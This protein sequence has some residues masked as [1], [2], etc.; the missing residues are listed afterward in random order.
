MIV[1]GFRHCRKVLLF[2]IIFL[3]CTAGYS[4]VIQCGTINTPIEN[5]AELKKEGTLR[6]KSNC[7]IRISINIITQQDGFHLA[8]NEDR[9]NREVDIANT[10]FDS[11]GITLILTEIK[12]IAREDLY[13][14]EVNTSNVD[15]LAAFNTQDVISLYIVNSINNS[16][17]AFTSFP[18]SNRSAIVMNRLCVDSYNFSHQ[19]GHYLGLLDTHFIGSGIE[20][21][22]GSN[23]EI[24]GDFLCDTPADPNLTFAVIDSDCEYQGMF[25]PED[26]VDLNGD[27]YNPNVRLVMSYTTVNCGTRF[28]TQQGVIMKNVIDSFYPD[29]LIDPTT[30]STTDED[31]NLGIKVY[32]NPVS[33]I[34]NLESEKINA[35]IDLEVY[36]ID[37]KLVKVAINKNQLHLSNIKEGVY[38]LKMS[39]A[40]SGKTQLERIVIRR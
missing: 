18:L 24:A 7:K 16:T 3:I 5:F 31:I 12:Y 14:L 6:L 28:T 25:D 26:E 9:I 40:F 37:G 4:Q 35:N 30:V 23:C 36:S 33:N 21:V 34:L 15:G 2:T 1:N 20:L 8:P 10:Y 27:R 13:D 39:D 17:C 32:P 22:D 11:I 29:I 19:I 38:I